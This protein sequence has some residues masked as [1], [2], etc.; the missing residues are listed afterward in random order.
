MLTPFSQIY[1][2]AQQ[3]LLKACPVLNGI[4]K[5]QGEIATEQSREVRPSALFGPAVG[6]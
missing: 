1:M 5:I 6:M 2:G 4:H 3:I